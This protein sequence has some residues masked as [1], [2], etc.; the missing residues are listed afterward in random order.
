M[1]EQFTFSL[2]P[3]ITEQ[4][5]PIISLSAPAPIKLPDAFTELF[6][7]PAIVDQQP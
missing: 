6:L 4:H 2:P 3:T 5:A 7:P 1:F